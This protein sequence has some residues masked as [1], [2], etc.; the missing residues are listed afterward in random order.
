MII[1]IVSDLHVE[2]WKKFPYIWERYKQS[3]VVVIA[4]DISDSVDL[5]IHELIKACQVYKYVIFVDGNHESGDLNQSSYDLDKSI[6]IIYERMKGYSNFFSLHHEICRFENIAF[7]GSCLWWNFSNSLQV[8]Q[9]FSLYMD[10]STIERIENTA[11]THA[12][13]LH[14]QILQLS[15]DSSIDTIVVVTHTLP[16]SVFVS[17]TNYP[18]S[19]KY[20]PMYFNSRGESFFDY[21]KVKYFIFGHSHDAKIRYVNDKLCINNARGRPFDFNRENYAPY[22]V[23][24][25]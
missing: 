25:K 16:H 20:K 9:Q 8:K 5:T 24:I 12:D 21:P 19:D 18:S 22:T 4:G 14:N 17:D 11:N 15:K 6:N 7:I 23:V 13:I 3:E 1:D 2:H 10:P